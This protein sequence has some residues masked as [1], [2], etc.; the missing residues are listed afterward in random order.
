MSPS[1]VRRQTGGFGKAFAEHEVH[2]KDNIQKVQRWR[3][4][5]TEL[6]N[7]PACRDLQDR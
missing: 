4:A 7:L 3:V 1:E 2:F 6:V 5:I